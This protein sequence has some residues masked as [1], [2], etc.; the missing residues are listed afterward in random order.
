MLTYVSI[1]SS[2][3]VATAHTVINLPIVVIVDEFV[4]D[5]S[6]LSDAENSTVVVEITFATFSLPN[7]GDVGR[8]QDGWVCPCS[9][10]LIQ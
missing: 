6:N 9:F 5:G 3:N 2:T 4:Q 10:Y 1:F 8:S 7:A